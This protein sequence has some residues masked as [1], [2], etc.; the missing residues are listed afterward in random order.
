MH[1]GDIILV[2]NGRLKMQVTEKQQ[3]TLTLLAKTGGEIDDGKSVNIP[4]KKLSVPTLSRKDLEMMEFARAKDE[5]LKY[6]LEI[7]LTNGGWGKVQAKL[8]FQERKAVVRIRNSVTTRQTKAKE[9]VCHFISRFITGALAVIF[10]KKAECV[11][12]RCE[13]KGDP[14]CEFRV[15]GQDEYTQK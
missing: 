1:V 15:D 13:A 14:F 8:N 12:I 11:E 5:E 3:K 6:A 2:D 9:P 10:S 7:F 4:H